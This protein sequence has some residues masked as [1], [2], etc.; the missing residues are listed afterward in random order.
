MVH[1]ERDGMGPNGG[2]EKMGGGGMAIDVKQRD[3]V[4]LTAESLMGV[5]LRRDEKKGGEAKA[6]QGGDVIKCGVSVPVTDT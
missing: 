6:R 2:S 1:D 5:G 3:R 4:Q